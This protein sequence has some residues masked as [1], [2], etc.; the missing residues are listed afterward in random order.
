VDWSITVVGNSVQTVSPN[1]YSAANCEISISYTSTSSSMM[2][3]INCDLIENV[4]LIHIHYITGS[5]SVLHES[6]GDVLLPIPVTDFPIVIDFPTIDAAQLQYICTDQTY[7]NI[8]TSSEPGGEVRANIVGMNAICNLGSAPRINQI[9]S[10]GTAPVGGGIQPFAVSFTATGT[11]TGTCS[12]IVAWDGIQSIFVSGNCTGL[13]GPIEYLY[14]YDGSDILFTVTSLTFNNDQPFSFTITPVMDF[15]LVKI[16]G[17]T[18]SLR[19]ITTAQASGEVQVSITGTCPQNTANCQPFSG[20]A[21]TAPATCYSGVKQNL[22]GNN[23]LTTT[24]CSAGQICGGI[25][26]SVSNPAQYFFGCYSVETC[27][28]CQSALTG[29]SVV[30]EKITCCTGDLCNCNENFDC[31]SSKGYRINMSLL[32]LWIMSF[33][34]MKLN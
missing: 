7:L 33:L 26:Q 34:I 24:T 29:S 30:T 5:G 21:P 15:D 28:I 12:V 13:S 31:T 11:N 4:T 14:L 1:V 10:W 19:Y 3:T 6:I 22:F 23:L 9:Q 16:C 20:S 8:H 27:Y 2:G 17:G 18:T 25:E 32:M